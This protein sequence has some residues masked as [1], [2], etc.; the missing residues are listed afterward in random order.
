MI[1]AFF[2]D[3]IQAAFEKLMDLGVKFTTEPTEAGTVTTAI[4]D[5]TRGNLI[6]IVME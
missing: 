4:F 2:V 3:D 6:Q 5:D 1:P